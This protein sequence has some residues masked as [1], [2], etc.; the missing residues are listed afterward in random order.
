MLLFVVFVPLLLLETFIYSMWFQIQKQSEMQANL[1]LARAVG[2]NFETFLDSLIRNELAVGLAL[3]AS[4]PPTDADKKRLL[5][6]IETDNPAVHNIFWL[7]SSGTV[8]ASTIEGFVGFDLSER[9]FYRRVKEGQDWAVSELIIGKITNKPIF[10]VS[11]AIRSENGKLIGVVAAAVDPDRLDRVLGI[12]RSKEAGVSLVDNKGMHVYRYP[13]TKFT[14]EQ[15]NW[16]KF[17]PIIEEPLK[18]KEVVATLVSEMT[19]KSRLAAFT[20]VSSIGWVASCSRAEDE[21]MAGITKTLLPMGLLTLLGTLAAFGIAV[22]LSRPITASIVR[23]RNHAAA[24]GRGEMASVE[25]ASGPREVKE[26]GKAFNEMAEKVRSREEAL[27]QARDGFEQRVKER[28]EELQRAY[29]RLLVEMKQREQAEEQLRQ[30]Q[31]MEAIGTLAGGIAHDFNN[32]LAVILG[33]A[34]LALDEIGQSNDGVGHEIEQIV[35]ASKRAKELVRHILAFSRKSQGQRKPLKVTPLVKETAKLLRASVPSTIDIN[36]DSSTE[37]DIIVA[38]PSQIQQVLM[39]LSTNAAYAMN[40]DGGILT[41]GVSDATFGEEHPRPDS[42]MQPGR[43]VVLT[44]RDTGTGIPENIR[45]RMFDPFFTT[46]EPSQGT[47]MGLAVVFGIAKSH[48]GAVTVESEVGKG[49]TFR[50]FFPLYEGAAQEEPAKE[51]SLPRGTEKVL[52]VDDEPSVVEV[53]A[54]TLRRLDY[55]VTTA[56]SGPEG[57]KKFKDRPQ[58]FDLVI[59]DHVMPEMTGIRLAE[60]MLEVRSDLPIILFTGYSEAVSAEQAKA[61]GIGEFLIKPIVARELAETVRRVL[62]GRDNA[63]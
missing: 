59:T 8:L 32:M 53:A 3:T 29:D 10:T 43:Y 39:N 61:R 7:D 63:E 1:E 21:V 26:L 27:R 23:V 44:V 55:Q 38:D 6:T 30:S 37:A 58:E 2:K 9:S 25:I 11:R 36:V 17:Y 16:L 12:D 46:K 41:I 19:G 45:N 20:P 54:A 4:R 28:T 13:R 5:H 22:G 50:V 42:D 33:N 62:D 52:V 48:G 40:K 60:K 18:G 24:L 47:G 51:V 49:S 57:W 15:R 34:E 35:K 31:K 14:W 56:G